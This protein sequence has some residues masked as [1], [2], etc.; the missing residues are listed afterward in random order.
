MALTRAEHLVN[1]R[2]ACSVMTSK[3]E[4]YEVFRYKV[5]YPGGTYLRISPAIDAEKTGTVL[6]FGTIF[7]ASKSLFLDGVN[8]AKV[9]HGN[10]WVFEKKDDVQILELLQ[11]I[12]VPVKKIQED[13]E[14]CE[15]QM[16]AENV[17]AQASSTSTNSVSAQAL[18]IPLTG[19]RAGAAVLTPSGIESDESCLTNYTIPTQRHTK[20][21]NRLWRDVRARCGACATFDEFLQLVTVLKISIDGLHAPHEQRVLNSINLIASITGQCSAQV[22]KDRGCMRGVDVSTCLWVLVHMG[23]RVSHTMSLIVEAANLIFESASTLKKA[24]LLR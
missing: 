7:D 23:S 1:N 15:K 6:E 4:T 22:I 21:E 3:M 9:S 17:D 8:Y 13:I 12:R 5:V 11:I 14:S 18:H 2:S 20:V 16:S 24:Y 19:D 10:G